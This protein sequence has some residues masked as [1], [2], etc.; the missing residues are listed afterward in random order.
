MGEKCYTPLTPAITTIVF[1]INEMNTNTKSIE[2]P[3]HFFVVQRVTATNIC[4]SAETE[5][6]Y[7]VIHSQT[8]Q[9][10]STVCGSNEERMEF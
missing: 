7:Q 5:V 2:A 9:V 10:K 8:D 3:N 1:V 4:E 6:Q